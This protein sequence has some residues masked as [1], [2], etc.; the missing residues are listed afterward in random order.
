MPTPEYRVAFRQSSPS[1]GFAEIES[2]SGLSGVRTVR[3]DH[4]DH[5]LRRMVSSLIPEAV[6]DFVDIFLSLRDVD[7]AV[8]RSWSGDR[9]ERARDPRR[10]VISFPVRD[11]A[12]WS[13][14]RPSSLLRDIVSLVSGEEL[15]PIFEPIS[16][17]RT[18]EWDKQLRLDIDIAPDFDAVMLFSGGLDSLYGM[19]ACLQR[20]NDGRILAVSANTNSRHTGLQR[21]LIRPLMLPKP[22]GKWEASIAYLPIL[23][24]ISAPREMRESTYRMRVLGFLAEGVLAAI[25][26][27]NDR[28]LLAENGPG[29]INLASNFA[30]GGASLNRGTHPATL[31]LVS[32]LVSL[33]F[34]REFEIENVGLHLTKRQ[35]VRTLEEY[36]FGA[37]IH[38]QTHVIVFRIPTRIPTVHMFVLS[39]ASNSFAG[40]QLG[41]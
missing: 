11:P 22:Y 30:L 10:L 40:S 32:E 27:G 31:R 20:I 41:V 28:L 7:R 17:C 33:A 18:R 12:F 26:A 37:L 35:M 2:R 13:G 34:G 1:T 4:G 29:A 15:E 3:Y 19:Y 25:A 5:H 38:L 21:R 36:G 16:S 23:A 9:R 39:V 8:P 24:A 14:G 6:W